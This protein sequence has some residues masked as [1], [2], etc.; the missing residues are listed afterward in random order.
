MTRARLAMAAGAAVLWWTASAG[1]ATRCL[2]RCQ[3]ERGVRRRQL[4]ACL[5]QAA[6]GSPDARARARLE[7]RRRTVIPSCDALPPCGDGETAPVGVDIVAR[8]FAKTEDGEPLSEAVYRPGDT[9]H[10]RYQG[11][12]SPDP[13]GSEI[14]LHADVALKDGARTLEARPKNL[15]MD[16]RLTAAESERPVKFGGRTSFVLPA[17]LRAGEYVVEVS[18]RESRSG[19]AAVRGYRFTV[20]APGKASK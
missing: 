7:C 17:D 16:R 14:A 13:A 4:D 6:A 20:G 19:I 8:Y 1:A 9:V 12:L 10:F 2:E 18:L 5:Q 15:T 3:K 11:L